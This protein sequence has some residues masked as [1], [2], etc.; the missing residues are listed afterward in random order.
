MSAAGIRDYAAFNED[1]IAEYVQEKQANRNGQLV[2]ACGDVAELKFADG[3]WSCLVH[4]ET[5]ANEL[6]LAKA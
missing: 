2:V 5:A 6:Y 4:A 1:E 3:Q